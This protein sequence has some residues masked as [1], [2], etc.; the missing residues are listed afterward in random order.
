MDKVKML[1]NEIESLK[2]HLRH[3]ME[4]KADKQKILKLNGQIDDLI[5]QFHELSKK[6]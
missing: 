5:N 4:E 2:A 6:S 1:K 3:L